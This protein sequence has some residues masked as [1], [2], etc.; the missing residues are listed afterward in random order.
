MTYPGGMAHRPM[1]DGTLL[2]RH[3]E[4]GMPLSCWLVTDRRP[5]RVVSLEIDTPAPP[6]LI[7]LSATYRVPLSPLPSASIRTAK[8]HTYH[9]DRAAI[10]YTLRTTKSGRKLRR[11]H[12]ARPS[13]SGGAPI[14]HR[15]GDIEPGGD[16]TPGV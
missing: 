7:P 13:L 2:I 9:L 16:A 10:T 11:M 3:D 12:L 5:Q 6:D 14:E 4:Q 15:G 1:T 8:G